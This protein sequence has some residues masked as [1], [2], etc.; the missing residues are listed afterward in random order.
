MHSAP[1]DLDAAILHQCMYAISYALA[2]L[3]RSRDSAPLAKPLTWLLLAN[4]WSKLQPLQGHK[5]PF[6]KPCCDPQKLTYSCCSDLNPPLPAHECKPDGRH[7]SIPHPNL[8]CHTNLKQ[9]SGHSRCTHDI[10]LAPLNCCWRLQSPQLPVL[11]PRKMLSTG[12]QPA[13]LPWAGSGAAHRAMQL[14]CCAPECRATLTCTA[15]QFRT[16]CCR[17][18]GWHHR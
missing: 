6:F 13:C 7:A 5:V 10:S 15:A 8:Q 1:P 9:P 14:T 3:T 12:A 4:A 17:A 18:D 16:N 11:Q 2:S